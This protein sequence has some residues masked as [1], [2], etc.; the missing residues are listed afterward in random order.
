[1]S[2]YIVFFASIAL[3]AFIAVFAWESAHPVLRANNNDKKRQILP[4]PLN[5]PIPNNQPNFVMTIRYGENLRHSAEYMLEA[6][7][8]QIAAQT[9]LEFL[10]NSNTTFN[11]RTEPEM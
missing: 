8:A 4:Q 1:M 6:R 7:K 2:A 3:I 10:R 11:R 5:R 9:A